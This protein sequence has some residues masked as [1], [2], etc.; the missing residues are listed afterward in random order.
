MKITLLFAA[1]LLIST[2]S[3]AQ[4][5]TSDANAQ[6]TVKANA[7]ST[8]NDKAMRDTKK[9]EKTVSTG[10]KAAIDQ[11]KSSVKA[12]KKTADQDAKVS[13]SSQT[14][15][16]SNTT[17]KS[18]NSGKDASLKEQSSTSASTSVNVNSEKVKNG[19]KKTEDATAGALV[20][21]GQ[22][23]K[24]TM[25]STDDKVEAKET[26]VKRSIKPMSASVKVNTHIATGAGIKI[27]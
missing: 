2:A 18:N 22:R 23:A 14:E 26:A 12:A 27:K 8:V 24:A 15:L 1:V 5:A 20:K 3:F 6:A 10:K 16:S 7:V 9:T 25:K 4:S 13:T 17:G 11:S 19:G 21:T